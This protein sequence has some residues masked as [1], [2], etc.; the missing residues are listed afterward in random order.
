MR[1]TA[2]MWLAPCELSHA[3]GGEAAAVSVAA[4][5]PPKATAAT[6][7]SRKAHDK[8]QHGHS[9]AAAVVP[10]ASAV[11][12]S[13]GGFASTPLLR[14][15]VTARNS[16]GPSACPSLLMGCS[17][18][19]LVGKGVGEPD[20]MVASLLTAGAP[21]VVGALWDVTDKDIDRYTCSLLT[22]WLGGDDAAD[23]SSGGSGGAGDRYSHRRTPAASTAGDEHCVVS[24]PPPSAAL[25]VAIGAARG[26][27]RLPYL[28]GSAPV[29]SGMP[30]WSKFTNE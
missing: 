28:I 16:S 27:C 15:Q 21:A 4:V 6:A 30:V 22:G 29:C 1:E 10:T 20:G 2:A 13:G 24:P 17:S 26:V 18:A 23:S 3:R 14:Q 9:T 5:L 11:P 25:S 7:K 12:A 19:R 8:Q